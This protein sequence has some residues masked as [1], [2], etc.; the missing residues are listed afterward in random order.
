MDVKLGSRAYPIMYGREISEGFTRTI[1]DRFPGKR[2]VIVT[3]TTLAKKYASLLEV[4][5]NDLDAPIV[6]IPDGERYKTVRTW[7]KLLDSLFEARLERS[8]L[9]IAF[10]GGVVGDICGFAAAS[11]LRGI[12]YVQV[13]TT[14]LAMV[15]SSVGGKTAVNHP[16]GKNLIGAFHQPS[17]VW[18][19]TTF[20][21]TLPKRQLLAGYLELFKYG[22]IGGESM[23]SFVRTNHEQLRNPDS[24]VLLEGIRRGLQIKADI[25]AEDERETSGRRALLNFGHTFGHSLERLYQYRGILH[26]EAVG[27]GIACACDLG[28]RIGT[29]RP[30]HVADYDSILEGL[31]LRGLK[32]D[33][34]LDVLYK[35]MFSDK[36]VES[37]RIRFIVPTD[38]GVSIVT[39]DVLPE[40]VQATL[41]KVLTPPS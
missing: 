37:G 27:W 21:S 31:P 30:E 14:L 6:T 32:K 9:L 23:F 10:G 28:I 19:D 41:L 11:Y 1:K 3:N 35:G 18:I 40:A 16:T 17:L 5:G 36:K 13:P 4:W 12:S 8:S 15:D 25:V 38:P 2:A 7:Q 33:I 26:G 29:I 24:P 34:D 39:P 20:L 22:F